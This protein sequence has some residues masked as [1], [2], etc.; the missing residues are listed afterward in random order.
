MGYTRTR[1]D[2][3]DLDPAEGVE[4]LMP[5]CVRPRVVRVADNVVSTDD[6]EQEDAPR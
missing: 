2:V 3:S 5:I 6:V 4:L 1:H